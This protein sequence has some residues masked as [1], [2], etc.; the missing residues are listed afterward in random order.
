MVLKIKELKNFVNSSSLSP[1][2]LKAFFQKKKEKK[3]A[4]LLVAIAETGAL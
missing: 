3:K 2:L 1:C 4:Q